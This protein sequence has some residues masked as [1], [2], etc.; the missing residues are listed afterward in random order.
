MVSCSSNHEPTCR[1][2]ATVTGQTSV[3][4]TLMQLMLNFASCCRVPK[5]KNSVL[6][7]FNIRL[8]EFIQ[9]LI[10]LIL[11]VSHGLDGKISI[12]RSIRAEWYIQLC[13]VRVA[14]DLWEVE[15]NDLKQF[16]HV[17][18]E[19]QGAQTWTLRNTLKTLNENS[20]KRISAS[21]CEGV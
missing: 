2:I 1:F 21:K 9:L 8:S 12:R 7:S 16:G 10:S 6:S 20:P 17:G 15:F 3:D 13:V 19:K 11:W 4:P 18:I 14:V 5:I